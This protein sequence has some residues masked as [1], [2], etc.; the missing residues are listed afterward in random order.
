MS[1]EVLALAHM[2]VEELSE[3]AA[4]R[5]AGHARRF[6]CHGLD[7]R[8]ENSLSTVLYRLLPQIVP[9]GIVDFD[10]E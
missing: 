6:S 4:S 7:S 5:V 3:A 10:Y 9:I 1:E 8:S 2:E